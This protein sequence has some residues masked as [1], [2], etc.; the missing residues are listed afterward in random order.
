MIN[1]V[2]YIFLT[3]VNALLA[4]YLYD[5]NLYPTL[6]IILW[7]CGGVWAFLALF[8]FLVEITYEANK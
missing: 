6:V 1:V 4:A 5:N 7:I 8:T 2:K 3:M